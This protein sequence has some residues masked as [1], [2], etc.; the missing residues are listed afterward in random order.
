VLCAFRYVVLFLLL[1]ILRGAAAGFKADISKELTCI[2]HKK[3][4]QSAHS[5]GIT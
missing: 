1:Q 4:S 5:S 3:I 2:I